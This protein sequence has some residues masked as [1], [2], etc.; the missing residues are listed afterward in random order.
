[1]WQT[2]VLKILTSQWLDRK[3]GTMVIHGAVGYF[4]TKITGIF[5]VAQK[6]LT[7]IMRLH[8]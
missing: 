6:Q 1:M 2:Q 5:R 4:R 7:A 8:C 3:I